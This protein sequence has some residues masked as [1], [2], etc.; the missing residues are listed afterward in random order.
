MLFAVPQVAKRLLEEFDKSGATKRF[1][2][3]CKAV[4]QLA[5]FHE[6]VTTMQANFAEV[7]RRDQ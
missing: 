6:D 1:M 2:G 3:V 4:G 7:R 5:D